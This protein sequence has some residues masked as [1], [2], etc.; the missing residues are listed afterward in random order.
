VTAV[1]YAK[2]CVAKLRWLLGDALLMP[3]QLPL[4]K[5][6][7]VVLTIG[8]LLTWLDTLVR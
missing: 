1:I 5:I 2:Y 6:G 4:M 3:I 8:L 7:V